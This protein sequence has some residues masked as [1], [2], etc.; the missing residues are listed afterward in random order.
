MS[1]YIFKQVNVSLEPRAPGLDSV[2][3][4]G[5]DKFLIQFDVGVLVPLRHC[6]YELTQ[7]RVSFFGSLSHL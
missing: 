7:D 4:V 3:K 5:Q 1:L 6:S 2:F